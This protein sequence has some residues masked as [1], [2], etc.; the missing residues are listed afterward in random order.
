MKTYICVYLGSALLALV[1]TPITMLL[2][3]RLNIADVPG[4]RQIHPEP[5]PHIGGVAIFLSMMS[6]TVAVLFLSNVIGD[7]FRDI[8]VKV[9]ALLSAAAFVFVVGLID[10]IKVGGLGAKQK[11]LAQICAALA[12]CS[13]GIRI[14]SLIVA[15]WLTLN[16]SWLSW[17]LTLLW[18]VGI[19]N[20]VNLIDGLDGLAAGIS[21]I[22]CAVV[23]VL[24]LHVGN[25]V[26]AVLMLALLGS[27]TG[28]LFFNFNPAKIFMGD[29]GSM[30]LGF[31]IASASVLCS[32][33]SP[34]LVGLAL[35][36]LVLGIPIFDTLLSI[37]RRFLER[38]SIF[39]ADRGHFHHRLVDM[40]VTQNRV[41]ILSYAV[42]IV[43][44]GLGMLMMITRNGVSLLVFFAALLLL[45]I[46]FRACGGV[47]LK[48]VLA[49]VQRKVAVSKREREETRSF[50]HAQ[51]HFRRVK[52]FGE[53]WQAIS[54]TAD[55][56]GFSR[57]RLPLMRR[58]GTRH[59]LIWQ[60]DDPGYGSH[61]G[62]LKAS[63]PVRDRRSGSSLNLD[64]E[65]CKNGSLES[66]G[67]R[68]AL[69]ARLMDEYGAGSLPQNG[70]G[71]K[72]L[73]A[74]K[75]HLRPSA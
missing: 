44:G 4:H 69:F 68:I 1:I 19:T 24:A 2:A 58:D 33:K 63:I 65:V 45:L 17:P 41:V 43:V 12:V 46:A 20:A 11:F 35:P 3:R 22:A 71:L 64:V 21:A 49:A 38:R 50:E 75:N 31:T 66:A 73:E 62:V 40:G 47:R 59:V 74:K 8:L 56:M 13:A 36:V 7:M 48:E 55:K 23:A 25:V 53:W 37:L 28:F 30:F 60:C 72:S 18:I 9:I 27:L 39:A 16:F 15:D 70:T 10:D 32:T 26:M 14:E 54:A 67:R 52:T 6:M 57:T 61:D 42:T 29:C 51:L 5:T 34:V